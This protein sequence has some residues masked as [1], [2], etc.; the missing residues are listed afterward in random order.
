MANY[1]YFDWHGSK[2]GPVS[3]EQLKELL[4]K[5]VISRYTMLETENGDAKFE[6]LRL[7]RACLHY[8]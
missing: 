5:G 6:A 3:E 4:A 8:S 1:F 7:P 2:Q